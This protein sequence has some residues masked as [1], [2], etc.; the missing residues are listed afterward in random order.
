MRAAGD[1]LQEAV[2]KKTPPQ[3]I[4]K[5][6]ASSRG[7]LKVRKVNTVGCGFDG[8][9]AV[10]KPSKLFAKPPAMPSGESVANDNN[11]LLD[12]QEKDIKERQSLMAQK[13]RNIQSSD[14][15]TNNKFTG[16]RNSKATAGSGN[17]FLDSVHVDNVEEVLNAK[18]RFAVEADAE[19]YA[20]NRR[21]VVELET[22]ESKQANRKRLAPEK[23][24]QKIQREWVC[25][26]CPNRPHFSLPPKPCIS[27]GHKVSIKRVIKE[28]GSKE[29][30][31]SKLNE[32]AP[33]Q[34]G[35]MLG[36]GLEWS[37]S[38]FSSD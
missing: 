35:L 32:M 1:W 33:D 5:V 14:K 11:V 28:V 4:S 21:R 37:K 30:E 38:R 27:S 24:N 23:E 2:A 12:E 29:V 13:I 20:K 7:G 6:V 15:T 22:I 26:T 10:P 36:R 16:K 3:S 8:A 17:A 34:G 31:R 19:E 9:V 25:F 18:S